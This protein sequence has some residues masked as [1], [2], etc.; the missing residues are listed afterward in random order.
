MNLPTNQIIKLLAASSALLVPMLAWG[1]AAPLAGDAYITPGI[2]SN[3]GALP[4]ISVGGSG[5]QGLLL[6]DLG[7]IPASSPIA[8]ARL[9]FYV[10]NVS[11]T[12]AADLFTAGSSWTESTITGT[13]GLIPGTP[14]QTGI[15]ISVPGFI[16]VDVTTPVQLWVNGSA[17]T[18]FL[19]SAN[20]GATSFTVDCKENVGTS[21]AARNKEEVSA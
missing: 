3:F 1:Q 21:H 10:N 9:R 2:G 15:P 16:T 14:V 13:S 12:G 5:S 17:N 19:L 4:S 18:G 6:F 11:A 8:W 7:S 20:P